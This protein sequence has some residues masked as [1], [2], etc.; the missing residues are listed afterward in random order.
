LRFDVMGTASRLV[1]KALIRADN[2]VRGTHRLV[3]V[4]GG[5]VA[6]LFEPVEASL[7]E[8][9]TS[10]NVGVERWWAAAVR[11]PGVAAGDLVLAFGG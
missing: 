9:A 11:A 4:A 2:K 7:D 6:E 1:A 8:I 5:E 3:C 10:V